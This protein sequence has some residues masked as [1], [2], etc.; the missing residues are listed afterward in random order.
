MMSSD[1]H[2][3]SMLTA[4]LV[5][6]RNVQAVG[7]ACVC[8]RCD[9]QAGII[10][11]LSRRYLCDTTSATGKQMSRPKQGVTM[12]DVSASSQAVII[13]DTP[14]LNCQCES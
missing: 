14:P 7:C 12:T 3:L 11:F 5:T 8:L 9:D 4:D 13:A 6:S 2:K 1:R 10:A